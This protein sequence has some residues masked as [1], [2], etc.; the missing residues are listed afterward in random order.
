M[1][2]DAAGWLPNG[3]GNGLAN[4]LANGHSGTDPPPSVVFAWRAPFAAIAAGR[5][6]LNLSEI[7]WWRILVAILLWAALAW[8]HPMLFGVAAVT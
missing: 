7:G 3:L 1:P 8:A 6:K 4:Q 2:S 5:Q